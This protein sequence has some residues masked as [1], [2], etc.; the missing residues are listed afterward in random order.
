MIVALTLAGW[1]DLVASVLIAGAS[2]FAALIHALSGAGRRAARLAYAVLGCV[3]VSELA[4][5]AVRVSPMDTARGWALVTDVLTMH[6]T[7]WWIVRCVGLVA[8]ARCRVGSMLQIA[9][10]APWLLART[11]QSHAGAHGWTAALVEGVHLLAASAW[12]GGL[13]QF[14]CLARADLPA[15]S[16]RFRLLATASVAL[17]LT[18]GLYAALLHIQSPAALV[19]SDYGRVLLLKLAVVAVLLAVGASNWIQH[20]PTRL[21]VLRR[22]PLRTV[23]LEIA[24]ASLVLLLS[25][26]LGALPMPHPPP[27]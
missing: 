14:S 11:L 24:V 27:G 4:L 21:M 5:T 6:W 12:L 20:L 22:Q 9:L 17:L 1:F 2:L 7:L 23:Q 16:A 15:A 10:L 25:A 26:L 8:I 19:E 13:V 3:L 18:A